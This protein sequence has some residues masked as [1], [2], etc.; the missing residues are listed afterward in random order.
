MKSQGPEYEK[1]SALLASTF[2]CPM[3]KNKCLINTLKINIQF[4]LI[5][6]RVIHS[7]IKNGVIC[8]FIPKSPVTVSLNLR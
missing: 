5:L 3:T 2:N 7:Q 1:I 6:K 4:G 8:Y